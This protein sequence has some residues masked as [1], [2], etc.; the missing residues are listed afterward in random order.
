MECKKYVAGEGKRLL[1]LESFGLGDTVLCSKDRSLRLIEVDPEDAE[2]FQERYQKLTEE[3]YSTTHDEEAV[4]EALEGIKAQLLQE[5]EDKGY[6]LEPVAGK[7][8]S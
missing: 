1:N 6:S 8:E 5:L 4:N 3:S 2:Y 7:E